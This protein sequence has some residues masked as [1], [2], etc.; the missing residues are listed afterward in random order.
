MGA[1]ILRV[2]QG[3]L[4]KK[5]TKTKQRLS[6]QQRH[7]GHRWCLAA[8][9][10]LHLGQLPDHLDL[11]LQ[12]PLQRLLRSRLVVVLVLLQGEQLLADPLLRLG[13]RGQIWLVSAISFSSLWLLSTTISPLREK[14][15]RYLGVRL[16]LTA[17]HL[18]SG[19]QTVLIYQ[20][21]VRTA[22]CWISF[23]I[24]SPFIGGPLKDWVLQF[25]MFPEL[26]EWHCVQCFY[27]T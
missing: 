19:E 18:Q 10:Y 1:L 17:H 22:T 5:Q 25:A 11:L 24:L 15:V 26:F 16:Q 4:T 20:S 14:H 3:A 7:T 2:A 21:L 8:G 13:L 23:E 6:I 9:P 27:C 12:D